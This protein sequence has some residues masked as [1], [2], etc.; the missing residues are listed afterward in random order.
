VSPY[1]PAEQE[2]V[3]ARFTEMLRAATRDGGAKVAAGTKRPWWGD[4]SHE[5][6]LFSHLNRWKH[7]ERQDPDSGAHPL[8]H[9]AWRALAL[10]YQETVGRSEPSSDQP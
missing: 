1:D 5:A 3:L 6:A 9:L 7:G 8:V 10:A 4:P 2:V